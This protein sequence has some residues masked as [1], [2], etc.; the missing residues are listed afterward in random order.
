MELVNQV[1]KQEM[2]RLVHW[3]CRSFSNK[4]NF[5]RY[6]VDTHPDIIALQETW[7]KDSS[8][9]PNF[10][11]YSTIHKVRPDNQ[12]G[13]GI[14]FIICN[15]INYRLKTL[16]P[17][18]NPVMEIQCIT[19][20]LKNSEVDIVNIY[21]PPTTF[22][23]KEFNH[24]KKQLKNKFII[25]GDL[26]AHHT[27]WDPEYPMINQ[28]GTELNQILNSDTNL[29]IATP[30]GLI[31]HTDTNGQT[32]TLDLLLCNPALLTAF[33]ITTAP[34]FGSDHDPV[35][36]NI[37]ISPN[38]TVTGKRPKWKIIKKN[39]PQWIESLEWPTQN[40][41][42]ERVPGDLEQDYHN[43]TKSITEASTE[44]FK[45]TS[46]KTKY[47][48]H[49][50]WWNEQCSKATALRRR[51]KRRF[52]RSRTVENRIEYRKRHAEAM[53]THKYHKKQFWIKYVSTLNSNS[54]PGEVWTAVK[55]MSGK[56]KVSFHPLTE[57][58]IHHFTKEAKAQ[59]HVNYFQSQM[60]SRKKLNILSTSL[61]L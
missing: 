46:N 30:P 15:T 5:K 33:E 17:Y 38:K 25:C 54:K 53:R 2:L 8:Y 35:I 40:Q 29:C 42:I 18:K 13:G 51:A 52:Q 22:V 14:S 10:Q 45:K 23:K 3:N 27:T 57:N 1:N 47:N 55:K 59:I 48:I 32:S 26:N 41:L 19:V 39:W 21:S 36:A 56:N 61:I 58:G 37:E 12:K 20:Q 31:T 28:A 34:D 43:F 60:Y 11:S 7:F 16:K 44:Y 49:K 24:Y 4:I 50:P 6:I 9:K